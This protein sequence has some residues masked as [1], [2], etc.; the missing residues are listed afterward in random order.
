MKERLSVNSYANNH[1]IYDR[2]FASISQIVKTV[3]RKAEER[4]K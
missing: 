3:N 4:M 1:I 2:N